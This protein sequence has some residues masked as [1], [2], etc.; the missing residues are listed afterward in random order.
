MIKERQDITFLILTKRIDRFMTVL[1]TDWKEAFLSLLILP[2]RLDYK[3]YI[4]RR[5][6]FE[7][8]QHIG[9]CSITGRL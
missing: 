1:P 3:Y 9:D 4:L 2:E 7:K 5:M 8:K 6:L